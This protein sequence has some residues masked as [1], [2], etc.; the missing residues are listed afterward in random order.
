MSECQETFPGNEGRQYFGALFFVGGAGHQAAG[1]HHTRQI[2][3]QQQATAHRLHDDHGFS[4][5]ACEATVSL[6]KRQ[7]EQAQFGVAGPEF[8][9]PAIG[10]AQITRAL[11][12]AIAVG[13]QTVDRILYHALFFIEIEIHA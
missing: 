6:G 7:A 2:G 1:Q 9:T 8:T 10:L 12:K 11:F 13:D 4:R 5:T 3:L